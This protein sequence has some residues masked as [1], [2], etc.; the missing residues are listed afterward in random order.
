MMKVVVSA[1]MPASATRYLRKMSRKCVRETNR[2]RWEIRDVC[3]VRAC[4]FAWS[5]SVVVAGWEA[6]VGAVVDVV[7]D[8]FGP[9]GWLV[10]L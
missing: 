3:T 2:R 10:D 4:V 8:P 9:H 7:N 5:S 1:S 6:D